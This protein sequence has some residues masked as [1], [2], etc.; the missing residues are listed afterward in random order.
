[1][2]GENKTGAR[3]AVGLL[4]ALVAMLALASTAM[5]GAN[6]SVGDSRL[7][8]G[9]NDPYTSNVP[10]LAWNGEQIRLVKCFAGLPDVADSDV[11]LFVE[12]WSGDPFFKP[13]IEQSTVA[14]FVGT[15]ERR[16]DRCVRGSIVSLKPGLAV[17]K[18]VVSPNGGAAGDRVPVLK[19]QFLVIWLTLGNP[20]II[21]LPFGG[22]PDAS[23]NF[24]APFSNGRVQISVKGSFPL[25]N[26]FAGLIGDALNLSRHSLFL[27]DPD[28]LEAVRQ[29]A[30]REHT[31]DHQL[32][33]RHPSEF[34]AEGERVLPARIKIV[35]DND[36]AVH[37]CPPGAA[38]GSR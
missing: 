12:D 17:V 37:V 4:V 6:G 21:E 26:N 10:Y 38:F 11:E 23:G 14:D 22:D 19:H 27:H 32:G 35:P 33:A 30:G 13:N 5:A 20:T 2:K 8:N 3:L 15:G 31:S 7:K 16:G 18:L 1:M 9:S 24:R 28:L 25:G 29:H 34:T 36:L